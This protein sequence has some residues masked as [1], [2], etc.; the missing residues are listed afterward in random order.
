MFVETGDN[1]HPKYKSSFVIF[2]A[3]NENDFINLPA[4]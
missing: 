3:A 2:S 1:N 4:T